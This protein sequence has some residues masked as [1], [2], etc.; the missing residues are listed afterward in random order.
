[1]IVVF[2][3]IAA[4]DLPDH[5]TIASFTPRFLE[6]IEASFVQ[7]L[8][9]RE[10]GALQMGTLGLDGTKIHTNANSQ[11][12]LSY[13]HVGK[14][15]AQLQ[16]EVA[17]L[18]AKAEAADPS[19]LPDDLSLPEELAP[20]E[21]RRNCQESCVRGRTSHH[22]LT[23]LWWNMIANRVLASHHSRDGMTCSQ[24]RR[25]LC[26]IDGYLRPQTPASPAPCGPGLRPSPGR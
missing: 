20:R 19:D 9:A 21:E 8:L 23:N 18:L 15:E 6:Q 13:E 7:V 2:R 4:N 16:A 12:A 5:G 22:A 25:Q 14:I 10:M 3:F 26:A 24:F 1:V 11:S 17:T